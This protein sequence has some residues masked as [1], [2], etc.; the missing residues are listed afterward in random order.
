MLISIDNGKIISRIPYKSSY[1]TLKKRLSKEEFDA[2]TEELNSRI[3]SK[4]I[5]TSSWLPGSDWTGTVFYPIYSKACNENVEE[6]GKFF[7]LILWVVSDG[8]VLW[9]I[10]E[11]PKD[12]LREIRQASDG[13]V[14]PKLTES[15]RST[16]IKEKINGTNCSQ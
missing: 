11:K 9:R 7:G 10:Q 3:N 1:D 8:Y 12:L 16:L 5:L 13:G 2:I 15:E 6:A 4:Q 14:W